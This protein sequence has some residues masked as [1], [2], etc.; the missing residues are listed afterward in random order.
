METAV[1]KQNEIREGS[2]RQRIYSPAVD[3]YRKEDTFYLYADIPGAG[4]D[5]VDVSVEKN[6]LTIKAQVEQPRVDGKLVYAEYGVGNYERSFRLSEDIDVEGIQAR[7]KNGVLEL[8]IPVSKPS[9]RKIQVK[10]E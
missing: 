6:V 9:T 3:L 1:Q 8:T 2:V 5:S 7:V 10:S 4:E